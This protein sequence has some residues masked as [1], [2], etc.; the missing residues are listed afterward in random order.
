MNRE[1]DTEVWKTILSE[2]RLVHVNTSAVLKVEGRR[3]WLTRL[4]WGRL[5]TRFTGRSGL[6][7]VFTGRTEA[8]AKAFAVLRH[9]AGAGLRFSD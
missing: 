1:S 6:N 2:V 7:G 4:G 5:M 8:K 9:M 3:V